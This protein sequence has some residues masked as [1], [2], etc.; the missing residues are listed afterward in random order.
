[1]WTNGEEI[2]VFVVTQRYNP[3]IPG[4]CNQLTFSDPISI[5]ADDTVHHGFAG[6]CF[7]SL[8]SIPDY[9]PNVPANNPFFLADIICPPEMR[10]NTL[11]HPIA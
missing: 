9:N 3:Q 7:A 1:M 10:L 4:S 11:E 5:N 8:D 6:F 2:I